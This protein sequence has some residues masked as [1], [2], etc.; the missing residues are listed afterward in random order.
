MIVF[1]HTAKEGCDLLIYRLMDKMGMLE[2][3]GYLEN[4]SIVAECFPHMTM[5][6]ITVVL[7]VH[8]STKVK[9]VCRFYISATGIRFCQIPVNSVYLHFL[10]TSQHIFFSLN[11][12][13]NNHV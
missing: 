1:V 13:L 7:T 8:Q 12:L 9:T 11:L 2:I 10:I 6:M 3:L 4:R 5:I